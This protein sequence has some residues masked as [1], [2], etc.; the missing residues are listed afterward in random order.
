MAIRRLPF[1]AFRGSLGVSNLLKSVVG[2]LQFLE[3]DSKLP[4]AL[5]GG[6]LCLLNP[7]S[8][9]FRLKLFP[10]VVENHG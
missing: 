1:P 8:V 2:Q 4:A 9:V 3:I 10:L 6:V 5:V 7:G